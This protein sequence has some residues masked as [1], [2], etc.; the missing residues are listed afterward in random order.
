ME[1]I[2]GS[3]SLS[4][5]SGD[6]TSAPDGLVEGGLGG[7]RR[8]EPR[9]RPVLPTTPSNLESSHCEVASRAK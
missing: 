4:E 8:S 2:D 7:Q 6:A 3:L 9:I 1:L 5:W